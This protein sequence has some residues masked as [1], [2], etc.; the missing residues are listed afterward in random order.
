MLEILS[1]IVICPV[2]IAFL[3]VC[4]CGFQGA[5]HERP[6]YHGSKGRIAWTAPAVGIRFL[7]WRNSSGV[8]PRS[9]EFQPKA[10]HPI[11][12][13]PAPVLRRAR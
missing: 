7:T 13:V 12:R 2:A 10:P 9:S 3:V 1:L 6:S 5:L 8:L 4:F 11:R